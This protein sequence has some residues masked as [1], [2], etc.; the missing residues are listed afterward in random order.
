MSAPPTYLTALELSG[1]LL[2]LPEWFPSL[3]E[4]TK[5]TLSATVLGIDNLVILSALRSLFSLT[6]SVSAVKHDPDMAA[7]LEKNKSD[8]GGEIFVPAVGFS[9]LKL[10]RIF[11]PL[12]PSLNFS[13]KGTPQLERL[14]LRFKR[15]EGLQGMDKLAMLHDVVLT[16]DGQA[17]KPTKS[18]L[19]DL[20][21]L[22]SK[23]ALVFNENHD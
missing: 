17:S 3:I 12:L 20:K 4:L 9:K 15:L 18:I 14:E 13:K 11:V 5:L 7:I 22:S 21:G 23:Y 19:E 16:V 10:L 8:S 2:K 1:K 6:F